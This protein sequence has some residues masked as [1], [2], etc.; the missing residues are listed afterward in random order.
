MK[1]LVTQLCPIL[2]RTHELRPTT[3]LCP[4]D[5]SGKNTGVAIPFS[6]GSSRPSDRTWVSRNVDRTFT[7]SH[8][9]F[10]FTALFSCHLYSPT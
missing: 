2:L 8:F 9:R 5:S 1:T 6:R 3:L 4:W 7:E 10:S